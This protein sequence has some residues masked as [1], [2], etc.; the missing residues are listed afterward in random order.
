MRSALAVLAVRLT[1]FECLKPCHI[2]INVLAITCFTGSNDTGQVFNM[3]A[4]M[5]RVCRKCMAVCS[6]H[7]KLVKV[8]IASAAVLIDLAHRFLIPS[9]VSYDTLLHHQGIC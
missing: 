1:T 6:A 3:H 5:P 8:C 4:L 9:Y 7:I 2:R